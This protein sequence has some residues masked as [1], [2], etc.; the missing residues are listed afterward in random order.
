MGVVFTMQF[1][2]NKISIKGSYFPTG[3]FPSGI[4]SFYKNGQNVAKSLYISVKKRNHLRKFIKSVG[5]V[6]LRT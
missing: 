2:D 6:Q 3:D 5:S 4:T 1:L